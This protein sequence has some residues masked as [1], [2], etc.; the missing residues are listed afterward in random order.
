MNEEIE[1]ILDSAKESMG[2]AIEHL[3]KELELLEQEKLP[4]QC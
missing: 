3:I 1:F 2:N 4:P